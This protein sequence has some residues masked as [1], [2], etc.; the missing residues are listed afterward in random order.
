[1]PKDKKK[2]D[3]HDDHEDSGRYHEKKAHWEGHVEQ[4]DDHLSET[5]EMA[6][7]RYNEEENKRLVH[8]RTRIQREL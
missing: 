7:M 4:F 6:E 5:T 3:H 1:M 8:E 2:G